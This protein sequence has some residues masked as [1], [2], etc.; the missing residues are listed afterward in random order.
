MR[1]LA[2]VAVG[3]LLACSTERKA[4][5]VAH[6]PHGPLAALMTQHNTATCGVSGRTYATKFWQPPYQ[7]CQSTNADSTESA[8]IDADSVVVELYNS[9][10]VTPA[11]QAGVFSQA[12]DELTSRFGTPQSC[13]PTR[14]QW[15][16][17]DSLHIALQIAPIS[18]V[19]TELDEGPYR[20]TRVA[21][22]GPLDPA[23]WGC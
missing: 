1:L 4:S 3:V 6:A 15:R 20:L 11:V 16:S 2:T 10:T 13:S 19:G 8:E 22:L 18:Q 21:R 12:V 23:E 5:R 17:G 9:W 7:T 14:M